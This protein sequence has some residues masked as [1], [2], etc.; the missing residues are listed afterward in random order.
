MLSVHSFVERKYFLQLYKVAI[1][2]IRTLNRDSY[3]RVSSGPS[4]FQISPSFLT[5]KFT[6]DQQSHFQQNVRL[7][8]LPTVKPELMMLILNI[9][10][11]QRA[12]QNQDE[13]KFSP[14]GAIF[15]NTSTH[16]PKMLPT[17]YTLPLNN[18]FFFSNGRA[19]LRSRKKNEFFNWTKIR[20]KRNQ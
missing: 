10:P 4:Q 3:L 16:T 18:I 17:C 13:T 5:I 7:L 20:E 1:Y 12:K 14:P 19:K 8:Y 6:L 15:H 9:A 2:T 11:A